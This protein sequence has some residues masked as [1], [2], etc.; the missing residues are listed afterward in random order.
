M[1]RTPVQVLHHTTSR[2][3][4]GKPG[5]DGPKEGSGRSTAETSTYTIVCCGT[6][7]ASDTPPSVFS[8]NVVNSVAGVKAGVNEEAETA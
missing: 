8:G 4:G 7:E 1:E 5:P 2:G 6:K 3:F